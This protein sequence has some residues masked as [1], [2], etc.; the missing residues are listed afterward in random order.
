MR[1]TGNKDSASFYSNK[2]VQLIN[3][4]LQSD[5]LN[6]KAY[7]ALG[8]L[9]FSESNY[10]DAEQSFLQCLKFNKDTGSPEYEDYYRYLAGT[11]RK[12]KKYTE[13]KKYSNEL[14]KIIPNSAVP[15]YGLAKTYSLENDNKNAF[16]NL[17][18]SFKNGV[19][20]GLNDYN[21]VV[22]DADLSNIRSASEFKPLMKKYFPKEYKE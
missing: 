6:V 13:S 4:G 9:Y 10:A 16:L 17:E 15:F 19:I 14:I 22:A 3:V 21:S 12:L 5:S 18:K 2:M 20:T 11:E 1:L 8:S 7:Y